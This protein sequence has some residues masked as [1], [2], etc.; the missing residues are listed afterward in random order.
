MTILFN[1]RRELF[2]L[3]ERKLLQRAS[4]AEAVGYDF[5]RDVVRIPE[6]ESLDYQVVGKVCRIDVSLG[7]RL[8]HAL[9]VDLHDIHHLDEGFDAELY[10]L[11]RVEERL[12]V[13]L[14]V[15]VF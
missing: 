5:A 6:R 4:P 13:F 10:R 11:Y 3:F 7:S 8:I 1:E 14:Y 9:L 2:E 12:L 15:L